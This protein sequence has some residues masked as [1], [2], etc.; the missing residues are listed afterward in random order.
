MRG[1]SIKTYVDEHGNIKKADVE[2][3]IN[4]ERVSKYTLLIGSILVVKPL[5]KQKLK[6]RDRKVQVLSFK[7]SEND[8]LYGE[9]K[10][11]VKFLDNN[12]RGVIEIGDLDTFQE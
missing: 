5:N 8:K 12:R 4:D 3:Y 1:T 10:V 9:S 2:R 6:H 11:N 7:E